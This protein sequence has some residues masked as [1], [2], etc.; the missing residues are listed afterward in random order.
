MNSQ[1]TIFDYIKP[2]F[3]ESHDEI[4]RYDIEAKFT[5]MIPLQNCCEHVPEERFK[6]CREYFIQCSTCKSHTDCYQHLYEAKQAWNLG[7]RLL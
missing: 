5:R 7:R 3:H 6:S 4:I 2:N 1:M